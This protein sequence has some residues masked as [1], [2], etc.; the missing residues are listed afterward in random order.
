MDRDAVQAEYNAPDVEEV[1]DEYDQ[2]QRN[3]TPSGEGSSTNPFSF[4]DDN[5]ND[6][7]DWTWGFD[8]ADILGPRAQSPRDMVEILYV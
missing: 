7:E 3:G 2:A 4:V 1:E 8:L 6:E 5:N